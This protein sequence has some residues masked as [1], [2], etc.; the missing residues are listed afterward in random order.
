MPQCCACLA[1][2]WTARSQRAL[3]LLRRRIR[4]TP[5]PSSA[6]ARCV[7]TGP[8]DAQLPHIFG[9][10]DMQP[11]VAQ[12]YAEVA[13]LLDRFGRIAP[14][15]MTGTGSSVF[16]AFKDKERADSVQSKLPQG[17]HSIV[18]SG[19]AIHPLFTFSY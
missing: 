3:Y 1:V 6:L 4:L 14:A 8:G 11:L 15:R 18:A 7:R 19:L 9:R 17:M 2:V 12:E 13:H 5:F 16:A 10:N